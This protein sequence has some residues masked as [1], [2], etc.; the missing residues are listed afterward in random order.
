MTKKSKI[1]I[2]KKLATRHA[3][4]TRTTQSKALDQ[5]AVYLGFSHW[6]ALKLQEKKGWEPTEECISSLEKSI[7]ESNPFADGEEGCF[8]TLGGSFDGQEAQKSGDIDGVPYVMFVFQDD[9]HMEGEGWRIVVPEAPNASPAVRI[10]GLYS[11]D[12][13][14]NETKFLKKAL[15]ISEVEAKKV[16]A[17]ISSDWSRRSTK[18]NAKGVVRHPLFNDTDGRRIESDTWYCLRCN[19]ELAGREV[20]RNLW[21]CS[22]CGASPINIFSVPFWL[23]EGGEQPTPFCAPKGG[24]R[25][26]PVIEVVDNRLRLELNEENVILL[27][28]S[29]LIDDAANAGERLGA[30]LAEIS[31]DDEFGV[32][33]TFETD[34]WPEQKE[35]FQARA[36]AKALGVSFDQDIVLCEPPFAWPGIAEFS[37]NTLEYTESMLGAYKEQS[38]EQTKPEE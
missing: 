23:E 9:I 8:G 20:A 37:A 6:N 11:K 16:Q 30:L 24:G 32:W 1:E 5:V 27:I 15:A 35:A 33:V 17:R 2:L 7:N 22:S 26:E 36:V 3:R 29:A 38:K 31:F 34:Y 18:P 13:P 12:C 19:S 14:L 21:H 10:D 4:S 25:G 28:R